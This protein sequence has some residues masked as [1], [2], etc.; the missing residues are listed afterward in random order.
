MNNH[1]SIDDLKPLLTRNLRS[2]RQHFAL[3]RLKTFK[4]A[5]LECVSI[6]NNRFSIF[7]F[8]SF[9]KTL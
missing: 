9:S 4:A 3:T 8:Q 6:S 1:P 7:N 5:Q 2:G